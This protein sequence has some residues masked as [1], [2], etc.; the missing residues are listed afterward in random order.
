MTE[1]DKIFNK[2]YYVFKN[3]KFEQQFRN[4]IKMVV[5][6]ERVKARSEQLEKC[7]SAI[8]SVYG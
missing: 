2:Y 1:I 5:E 3:E 4:M 8:N 6:I 7:N